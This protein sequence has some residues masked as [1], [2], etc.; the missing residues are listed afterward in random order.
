M[1]YICFQS[2]RRRDDVAHR[3]NALSVAQHKHVLA[4]DN[5]HGES[6]IVDGQ[7]P[8][9]RSS[10]RVL[11]IFVHLLLDTHLVVG[12]VHYA[13]TQTRRVDEKLIVYFFFQFLCYCRTRLYC[14]YCNNIIVFVLF[15][16]RKMIG[17]RSRHRFVLL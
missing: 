8:G 11:G 15:L 3:G 6:A 7:R 16:R 13:E 10:D 12:V 17:T 9:P 2:H 5:V 14:T 4:A 1:F